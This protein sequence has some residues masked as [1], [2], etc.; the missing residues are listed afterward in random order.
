MI[1]KGNR[2]TYRYPAQIRFAHPI[3]YLIGQGSNPGC[4]GG[5]PATNRPSYN[6][7]TQISS[8]RA[9]VDIFYLLGGGSLSQLLRR[10]ERK[11]CSQPWQP[12]DSVV[13]SR[14]IL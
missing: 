4:R 3:S 11:K 5:K 9:N 1:G 2:S 8:M 10:T 12:D 7:A 6:T 13:T 14:H